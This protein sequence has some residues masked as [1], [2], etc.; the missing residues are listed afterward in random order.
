[1]KAILI[2]KEIIYLLF[3]RI[4]RYFVGNYFQLF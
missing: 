4:P 1:M 2:L 3:N